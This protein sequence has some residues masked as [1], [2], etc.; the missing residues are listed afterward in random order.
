MNARYV[1]EA[2]VMMFLG[3]VAFTL[4]AWAFGASSPLT[5]VW[6]ALYGFFSYVVWRLIVDSTESSLEEDG[7]DELTPLQVLLAL[8]T[9]IAIIAVVAG[10]F[11]IGLIG[12]ALFGGKRGVRAVDI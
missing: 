1:A 12:L 5:K 9:P 10:F 8:A 4:I 2:V 7:V 3:I 6:G 11:F